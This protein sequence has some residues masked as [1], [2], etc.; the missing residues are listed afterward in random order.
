M[1]ALISRL[2]HEFPVCRD[3]VEAHPQRAAV[4]AI[5]FRGSGRAH[6]LLIQRSYRVSA[7]A[8]EISFPGGIFKREDECLLNTALRET[9]EELGLR[10]DESS[11]IAQLP[12]AHTLTGF[13][14]TPFA[15]LLDNPPAY[16][17]NEDEVQAA[18]EA[19][20]SRLLA[21]QQP[22]TGYDK[23]LDMTVFWHKNH[24]IW[25]ATARILKFI[26]SLHAY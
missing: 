16:K 5:I 8:G 20:L 18:I 3:P 14:I 12:M 22:D 7:H 13:E 19:P 26:G 21:T 17:I 4:L 2:R 10:V 1:Q 15:A 6:I 24:R 11:V 23:S 9:R 25:G